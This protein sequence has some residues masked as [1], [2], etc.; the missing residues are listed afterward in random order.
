MM[1]QAGVAKS[2]L[3]TE[4][5]DLKISLQYL[6]P[7]PRL[8]LVSASSCYLELPKCHGGIDEVV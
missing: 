2:R 5:S 3:P 8:K 7:G 1:K 4:K 6:F